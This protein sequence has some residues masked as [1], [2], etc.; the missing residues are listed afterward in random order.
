ME[1]KDLIGFTLIDVNEGSHH[2]SNDSVLV[3][4]NGGN[5]VV[6]VNDL[7]DVTP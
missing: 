1:L 6:S 7:T 5:V 4:S 3:R 2:D